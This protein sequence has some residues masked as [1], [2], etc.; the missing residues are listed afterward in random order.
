MDKS[1]WD[2]I[3]RLKE[4]ISGVEPRGE[5]TLNTRTVKITLGMY[6]IQ[7]AI[8]ALWW[9]IKI[10]AF[11]PW[12]IF[13]ISFLQI[14]WFWNKVTNSW[15]ISHEYTYQQVSESDESVDSPQ[16]SFLAPIINIQNE[17]I[18]NKPNQVALDM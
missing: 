14:G 9:S 17:P 5:I 11:W 2:R 3:Q 4:S 6:L 7:S 13:I 15:K 10:S 8:I 1:L 18:T 12:L 16:Q